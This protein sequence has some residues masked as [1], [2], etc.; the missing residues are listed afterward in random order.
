MKSPLATLV[1]L[2]SYLKRTEHQIDTIMPEAINAALQVELDKNRTVYQADKGKVILTLRKKVP[3]IKQS[4]ELT[5][6]DELMVA[7]QTSLANRH[8][9]R[10]DRINAEIAEHRQAIADLEQQREELLTNKQLIKLKSDF[11]QQKEQ[12]SWIQPSLSV[13]LD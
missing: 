11:I 6:L 7:T 5:R 3:T 1:N 4:K 2:K 13:Y 9:K 8:A 10:I 12:E